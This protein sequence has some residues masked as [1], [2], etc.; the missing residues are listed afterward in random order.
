MYTYIY[1]YIYTYICNIYVD[2]SYA[3]KYLHITSH[4]THT[5]PTLSNV[6][7]GIDHDLSESPLVKKDDSNDD[8]VVMGWR[9]SSGTPGQARD[10]PNLHLSKH[11]HQNNIIRETKTNSWR[12]SK[13][14]ALEKVDS[15]FKYGHFLICI[16]DFWGVTNTTNTTTIILRKNPRIFCQKISLCRIA[17]KTRACPQHTQHMLYYL[18]ST[19]ASHQRLGSRGVLVS[20]TLNERIDSHSKTD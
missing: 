5:T 2:I 7:V 19:T 12:A 1:I 20:A 13:R 3:Q 16:L 11:H 14:W 6:T 15:G 4:H 10:S 8:S 18:L 17:T 9:S